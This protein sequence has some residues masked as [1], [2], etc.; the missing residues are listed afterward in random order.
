MIPVK[1]IRTSIEKNAGNTGIL[2]KSIGGTLKLMGKY[3]KT[4]I[5]TLLA[6]SAAKNIH[7][8]HQIVR[9]E[10]KNKILKDQNLILKEILKS[11]KK[12]PIKS[13]EKKLI[14]PPLT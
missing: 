5:A 13:R 8:L 11:N 1:E 3:P 10:T 9:E 4:T 2:W 14:I 7:P 12:E 6:L